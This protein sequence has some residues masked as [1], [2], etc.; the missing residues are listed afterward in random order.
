MTD[1][2]DMVRKTHLVGDFF[3]RQSKR[4]LRRLDFFLTRALPSSTPAIA[5]HNARTNVLDSCNHPSIDPG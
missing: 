5:D 4:H 2:V 3:G 1:L